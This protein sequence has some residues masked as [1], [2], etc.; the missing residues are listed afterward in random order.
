MGATPEDASPEQIAKILFP[1]LT[2]GGPHAYGW[3]SS[4]GE[5][6]SVYVTKYAGRA[7]TKAANKHFSEIDPDC[8]IF[9]G[10]TRFATHGSPLN[11]DNNHPVRHRN[12]IGVHNGIIYNYDEVLKTTGRWT[13]KSGAV[14]E[15]DSEA[16]FAA[17]QKWGHTKGLR[18][19]EGNMVA[20]YMNLSHPDVVV[21]ARSKDRPQHLGW[22][23]RGNLFWASERHAL[24]RLTRLGIKFVKFSGMSDHRILWVKAGRILNRYTYLTETTPDSL[25]TA[26]GKRE[27]AAMKA[28]R[29]RRAETRWADLKL[30]HHPLRFDPAKYRPESP[31]DRLLTAAEAAAQQKARKA[32]PVVL[33]APDGPVTSKSF[34]PGPEWE[35]TAL[36][37][38]RPSQ[39]IE[40]RNGPG[41]AAY[42][43]AIEEDRPRD[44]ERVAAAAEVA[45]VERRTPIAGDP[46]DEG[47]ERYFYQ[48]L[49][50]SPVDYVRA[51]ADAEGWGD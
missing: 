48:G 30:T 7:D 34:Y 4:R 38:P 22:T 40:E 49:W 24:E 1:A 46:D 28:A 44:A 33:N 31:K 47:E 41:L 11:L 10:H 36:A 6:G 9:I 14:S 45:L 23:D 20:V 19:L 12:I 27:R 15:V 50:L 37:A 13:Q 21:I 18:H 2:Q 25:L 5:P 26:A 39:A 43:K 3:L 16:I 32:R 42:L 17:V 29:L 8:K 35:G 51:I